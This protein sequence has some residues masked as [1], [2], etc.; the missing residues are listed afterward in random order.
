MKARLA[1]VALF[2]LGI[3]SLGQQAQSQLTLQ[4]VG[5]GFGAAGGVTAFDTGGWCQTNSGSVTCGQA[6]AGTGGT[7]V[8]FGGNYT[9]VG[10]PTCVIAFIQDNNGGPNSF[11]YGGTAMTSMG[12]PV[13][14]TGSVLIS[15]F[16]LASP[17]SGTQSIN[18]HNAGSGYTFAGFAVATF[19][20][21]GTNCVRSGSYLGTHYASVTT[22]TN[23]PIAGAT[24]DLLADFEAADTIG[25]FTPGAGQTARA[26]LGASTTCP[27]PGSIGGIAISTKTG[28][29]AGSMS[30]TA[31]GVNANAVDLAVSVQHQ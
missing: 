31:G 10:T 16:F 6:V 25:N 15:G 3:V 20:G 24:G 17:A 23:S 12:T 1:A 2:L 29:A 30:W 14:L 7:S 27:A 11:S 18:A 26:C 9:P 22:F 19:T 5:G 4:N 8:D 28:S 13:T 21:T